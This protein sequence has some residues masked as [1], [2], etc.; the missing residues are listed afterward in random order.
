MARTPAHQHEVVVN[1][2]GATTTRTGL[3]VHAEFDPG[4]Y[5]TGLTVPAT[6][7]DSLP[8]TEH[9]WHGK[10]NYTLRPEP[11]IALAAP[12]GDDRSQPDNRAPDWLH[13]PVICGVETPEFAARLA[14]VEQYILDHPPISLH[15]KRGR[16]RTLRRGPLSLADRLLVT[17]I[18]HR[19]KT[20]VRALTALLGSPR[21]AVGDAVH[22]ITPVLKGHGHPIKPAPITAAT[23][24]DLANLI[25]RDNTKTI[26]N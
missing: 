10:W 9:E 21:E 17:V 13:H 18:R 8:L 11:P 15:H 5:P 23:A 25:G 20:Q 7:M 24:Q 19:W 4:T 14:D 12:R 26:S 16:H 2:I 3:S 6:V 22:E 1:T